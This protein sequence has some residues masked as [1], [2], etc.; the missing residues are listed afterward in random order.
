MELRVAWDNGV[1]TW[2]QYSLVRE[3]Y[4]LLVKG[5]EASM[6]KKKIASSDHL[7]PE[8]IIQ[9][10]P[11]KGRVE[12]QVELAG[13]CDANHTNIMTFKEEEDTRYW[14]EGNAF[15]NKQCDRCGNDSRPV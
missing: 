1:Q 8:G 5:F 12:T 10:S 13:K 11:N 7:D 3:D 9:K 14:D 2:D 15:D 4:P 6:K